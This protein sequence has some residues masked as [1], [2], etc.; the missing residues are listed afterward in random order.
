MPQRTG[1][2]PKLL[3]Q[4]L[5]LAAVLALAGCA[6]GE[7]PEGPSEVGFTP[8]EFDSL[9][10][11]QDDTPAQAL[12]AFQAS[13][14]MMMRHPDTALGG[15]DITAARGGT[16]AQWMGACQ[17]LASVAP[18]DAAARTF[19]ETWFQPY[20]ISGGPKPQGLFTG[21]YE[22]EVRGARAPGGP[23]Q[24]PLLSLPTDIIIK[25]GHT[26]GRMDHGKLVPYW[27]RAEIEA[28]ALKRQRLGLI[29]LTDPVDVFML[30]IQG[31]GRVD[32][33]DGRV[34]RVSYAG[35][36][37]QPYVPI[38]RVLAE[39]GEMPLEQVTMQSI[40][41]WLHAHPGQAAELMNQNP[42]YVFFRER[43]NTHRE[44]GPPGA[45]G[46]LITPERSVAIDPAYIPLSA[47]MWIDTLDPLTGAKY[48]RL[49]IA[50]DTG[51]AIKGPIR[52]DIF[53]GWGP[54]AEERAGKMNRPGSAVI[55]LPR[56]TAR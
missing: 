40:S 2:L 3:P 4:G 53:W 32:L 23:Y 20:A 31:S 9:A 43:I 6:T 37:G 18:G 13:C 46:V 44:D 54:Q 11:W 22:P 36:N 50:Q 29:W 38:G 15:T 21:Y 30:Q 26:Q 35:Q 56:P 42:S 25:D 34:V 45:L 52:A 10:G 51:G 17:A 1:L 39:R 55:L 12:P 24:Y 47:P 33:P 14:A 8:V 48:Q 27:T 49:M 16:P 41:A 19:F 5:L 7:T 28:G